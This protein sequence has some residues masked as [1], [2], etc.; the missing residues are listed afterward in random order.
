MAA[1]DL[2]LSALADPRRRDV[3]SALGSRPATATTLARDLPITR[4][5][6]VKHLTVLEKSSLV[7]SHRAGREVRFEVRPETLTQTADWLATLAAQWDDRLAL[8]KQRAEAAD[9]GSA[10]RTGSAAAAP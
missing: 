3:L 10:T 5:A 6:V 4:Q 2:V 9:A 1:V 7:R 8:L